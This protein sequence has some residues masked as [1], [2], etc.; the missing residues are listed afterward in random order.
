MTEEEFEVRLSWA[1]G[2]SVADRWAGQDA[3]L[4]IGYQS[5]G[6]LVRDI[7]DLERKVKAA[8]LRAGEV[9]DEVSRVSAL[10]QSN[11]Q[12]VQH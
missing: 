7:R 4:G 9:D 10:L 5:E 12:I 8:R 2:S 6:E 1:D 3:L 11:N